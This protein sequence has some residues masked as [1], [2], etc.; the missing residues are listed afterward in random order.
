MDLIKIYQTKNSFVKILSH[1]EDQ[2]NFITISNYAN[3]GTVQNYVK[4]LKTANISL[5]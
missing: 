4:K 5:K 3:D 1:S 2:N